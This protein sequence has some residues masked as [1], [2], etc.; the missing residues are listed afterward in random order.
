MT[1]LAGGSSKRERARAETL[2]DCLGHAESPPG[3]QVLETVEKGG[4]AA[5]AG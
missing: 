5:M 4:E 3:E 2:P 1:W